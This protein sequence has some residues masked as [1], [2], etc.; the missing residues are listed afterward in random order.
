MKRPV[1]ICFLFE[2][3]RFFTFDN[4]I[5]LEISTRLSN[6]E[7]IKNYDVRFLTGCG[8]VFFTACFFEECLP[9]LYQY[10]CNKEK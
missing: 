4:P 6:L 1:K 5:K 3:D 9:F 10:W 2:G 8:K 7:N